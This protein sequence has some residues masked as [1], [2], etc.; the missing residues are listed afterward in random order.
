MT[1]PQEYAQTAA[2]YTPLSHEAE[3]PAESFVAQRTDS[4]VKPKYLD[5]ESRGGPVFFAS[6]TLGFLCLTAAIY[7]VLGS[8]WCLQELSSHRS[9][10]TGVQ[11]RLLSEDDANWMKECMQEGSK[12]QKGNHSNNERLAHSVW[13]PEGGPSQDEI[14]MR[15]PGSAGTAKKR[16]GRLPIES[17]NTYIGAL[18]QR[19]PTDEAE[20][21]RQINALTLPLSDYWNMKPSECMLLLR[22]KRRLQDILSFR[23][24]AL[25]K[26]HSLVLEQQYYE[27]V[28]AEVKQNWDSHSRYM[29][30]E[31]GQSLAFVGASITQKKRQLSKVRGSMQ[32]TVQHQM[33]RSICAQ[34]FASHRRSGK[35]I[36]LRAANAI[37]IAILVMKGGQ[38]A[39]YCLSDEDQEE[40]L[41]AG[42]EFVEKVERAVTDLS[43]QQQSSRLMYFDF[44]RRLE[45]YQRLRTTVSMF[46]LMLRSVA[47]SL[48]KEP[49][50]KEL[51][52]QMNRLLKGL[53]GA[54]RIIR[55]S[56]TENATAPR[57][58]PLFRYLCLWG[59]SDEGD[60]SQETQQGSGTKD[61]RRR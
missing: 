11:T 35:G 10:S 6:N 42:Q 16:R 53:D 43:R 51:D 13:D 17:V 46:S 60:C 21:R 15:S 12:E 14:P 44:R 31:A 58:R 33:Q 37:S 8:F 34:V 32:A 48:S 5:W 55:N 56:H 54:D 52:E 28:R 24:R 7:L 39:D 1:G 23:S 50:L 36:S 9:L 26:L 2:I 20:Y 18:S 29:L 4:H 30:R 49:L 22:A 40:L 59:A 45:K 57:G 47:M 38:P 3:P 25:S 19:L 61:T 41:R 27:R